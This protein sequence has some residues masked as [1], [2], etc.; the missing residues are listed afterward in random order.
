[1]HAATAAPS[2][3]STLAVIVRPLTRLRRA[4]DDTGLGRFQISTT[5]IRS[6]PCRRAAGACAIVLPRGRRPRLPTL[7]F[8]SLNA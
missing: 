6:L 5:V 3:A 8:V 7:P 2:T 1:M 4:Q